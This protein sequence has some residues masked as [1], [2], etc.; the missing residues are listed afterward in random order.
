MIPNFPDPFQIELFAQIWLCLFHFHFGL[1]LSYHD[2]NSPQG[3]YF[4]YKRTTTSLFFRLVL[5]YRVNKQVLKQ[6]RA[7]NQIP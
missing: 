5:L 1:F 3:Q 6:F 2:I 7:Q 4:L